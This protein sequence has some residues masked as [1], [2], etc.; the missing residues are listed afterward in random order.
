V[1]IFTMHDDEQHIGEMLE[2]G[3][4]GYVL[5][6]DH[7]KQLLHTI[8]SLAEHKSFFSPIISETLLGSFLTRHRSDG[9]NLSD[10]E[11]TLVRLIAEGHT[12]GQVAK[13][14][15]VSLNAVEKR[16]SE[17]MRRLHLPSAAAVVR[18]AIR[19]GLVEP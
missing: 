15:N 1:L 19:I 18:Y 14:L 2:A 4:R 17:I 12:N 3:A 9:T 5:K 13:I 10:W 7:T 8:E 11:R 6:S 16:R